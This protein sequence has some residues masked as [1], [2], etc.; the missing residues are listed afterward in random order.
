M[1]VNPVKKSPK[2][3]L[4]DTQPGDEHKA[5]IGETKQRRWGCQG[6]LGADN[7][8]EVGGCA[9][10]WGKSEGERVYWRHR[11]LRNWEQQGREWTWVGL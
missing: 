6:V 4:P 8:E 5:R 11:A 1:Q 10:L 3:L 9:V 2:Y 7:G